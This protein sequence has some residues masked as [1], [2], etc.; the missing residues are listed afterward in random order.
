M[1]ILLKKYFNQMVK[2]YISY[3][4]SHGLGYDFYPTICVFSGLGDGK[5]S[6]S[7]IKIICKPKPW[8]ILFITSYNTT[9]LFS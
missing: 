6:T 3:R 1:N 9:F 8:E 2:I 4:I 5:H 7:W